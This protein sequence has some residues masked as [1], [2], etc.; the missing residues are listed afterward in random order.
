M[1]S[2]GHRVTYE[3]L[4]LPT[5]PVPVIVITRGVVLPPMIVEAFAEILA[6]MFT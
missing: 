4:P 2:A 6:F 1:N 3:L 5:V